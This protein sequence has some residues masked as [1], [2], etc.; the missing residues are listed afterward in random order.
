MDVLDAVHWVPGGDVLAL[1]GDLFVAAG[2]DIPPGHGNSTA[3]STR[4]R[5]RCCGRRTDGRRRTP[6]G[7]TWPPANG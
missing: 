7:S 3:R 5:C 1:T 6:S 2:P 4:M